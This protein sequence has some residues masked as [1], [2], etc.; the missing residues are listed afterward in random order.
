MNFLQK[1]IKYKKKYLILKRQIGGTR[2]I[3]LKFLEDHFDKFKS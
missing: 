1:Y 2:E 3:K